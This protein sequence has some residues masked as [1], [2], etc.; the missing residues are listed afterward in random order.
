MHRLRLLAPF[1]FLLLAS[2]SKP[3]VVES[4][5]KSVVSAVQ[6]GELGRAQ[7][8]LDDAFG[9]GVLL[10]APGNP[11]TLIRSG[12]S[13]SD[14]D[15]LRLLQSEILLEQ[16]QFPAAL[17]LLANLKDPGDPESHLRWLVARAVG[18]SKTDKLSE[19]K[20]L[21][22]RVDQESGSL[23]SSEPALKARL[24]RGNLLSGSGK[25]GQANTLFRETESIA[26]RDGRTFYQ[27]A[28]RVNLSLSS[29]RQQRYDESVEYAQNA[30]KGL[31]AGNLRLAALLHNN[32]GIAYYRLGN[33]EKAKQHEENAVALSRK[34][35]DSRTIAD[36]LGG[37]A[38]VEIEDWSIDLKNFDA[39]VKA[40]EEALELS[41]KIGANGDAHRWAGNLATAHLAAYAFIKARGLDAGNRANNELAAAERANNEAY[42]LRNLLENPEK[43]QLLQFNAAEIA[44]G[45]SQPAEAEKLYRALIAEKPTGFIE[46]AAH[47]RLGKLFATEKNYKEAKREF[48]LALAAIEDERSNLK[49]TESR[50]TFN[51]HLIRFFWNYVDMLVDEGRT[52]E[53]LEVVEYSRARVMSEK[54]GV[55]RR[56]FA[57]VRAAALQGY[58]RRTGD[59]VLSYWLAPERSFVW[60]VTPNGIHWK[61]L[62]NR[63][64]I[65]DAV[66]VYRRAIEDL[67]DPVAENLASGEKLSSLLLDPVKQYLEGAPRVIV[68]PDG[69]M[70]L[71]N[72][73][74]LPVATKTG[75]QYWIESTEFAVSPS[76]ILLFQGLSAKKVPASPNMLLYGAPTSSRSEYPELPGTKLEIAG[77]QKYFE[78]RE[79]TVEGA[80]ATPRFFLNSMPAVYSMIHFAAH[81][82]ANLLSPLDS[83]VI[84]SEDS[85]GFKLYAWN[86]ARLKLS[87]NLV[88][89]SSCRGAGARSYNG[90][91]MFGFAWAFMQSGVRNVIAGLWDVDDAYSSQM[92]IALYK[93][94]AAGTRPST[95]L[96]E[97]K[98]ELLR[99][100]GTQ[101]KPVYWAPYQTYLR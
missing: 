62:E 49:Q 70:H 97:A 89:L 87:A 38:N 21:L 41:K 96:R 59:V 42:A 52:D 32:L 26:E 77:I 82:E 12:I 91:G 69:D 33:L 98:L 44:L 4:V 84:L 61:V 37:L 43:T 88:T 46:W 30:L 64:T 39:A 5:H 90:E 67:R 74:S 45:R 80:K 94:I 13:Q 83:A 99:S 40:L 11:D 54:L 17:E 60:A 15:R 20:A 6:S 86:I 76:L 25:F 35:G 29:L 71:L 85:Q 18:L 101:H 93:R 19:A 47:A 53:A 31:E 57:Q 8:I 92:M 55:E 75:K 3:P 23:T 1:L 56:S 63:Q 48:E 14:A 50:V 22:E 10:A 100:N 65:S 72:L 73:E 78:G 66:S 9:K 24:L 51:N 2:C 27:V 81:A 36:A 95:A 7:S 34:S 28:A 58:A 16:G 79:T 68:V